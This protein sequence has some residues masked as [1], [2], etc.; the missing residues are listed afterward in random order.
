MHPLKEFRHRQKNWISGWFKI[1]VTSL[2]KFWALVSEIE[3]IYLENGYLLIRFEDLSYVLRV[4]EDVLEKVAV[5][6]RVPNFPIEYYDKHVLWRI[7]NCIGRTL[8]IGFNT[9]RYNKGVETDY[10]IP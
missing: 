6:S 9:M 2:L 8:K 3:M 7:C 4:F 1:S 10:Y 5:W